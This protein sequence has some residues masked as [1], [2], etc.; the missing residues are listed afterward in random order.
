[1]KLH[2]PLPD[3]NRER[4]TSYG[5]QFQFSSRDDVITQGTDC[6]NYLCFAT[7]SMAETVE[8]TPLAADDDA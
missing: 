3:P 8:A 2:C 7:K 6:M 5:T 1:M 4:F